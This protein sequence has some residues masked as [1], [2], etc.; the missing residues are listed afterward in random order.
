MAY[1]CIVG[2]DQL[3]RE[4]IELLEIVGRMRHP[5]WRMPQPR[6]VLKNSNKE[7]LLLFLWI[8][9]VITQQTGAI[10]GLCLPTQRAMSGLLIQI[11][12]R[13]DNNSTNS[14]A[15]TLTKMIDYEPELEKVKD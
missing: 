15:C 8:S 1:I 4:V 5:G 7:L 13:N 3:D 9:V 11:E 10:M 12:S 2:F 6:Q 14:T